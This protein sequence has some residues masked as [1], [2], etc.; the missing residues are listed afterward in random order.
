VKVLN[1][2]SQTLTDPN[3]ASVVLLVSVGDKDIMLMG[4]AENEAQGN[5]AQDTL[6]K[7]EVY[8]VPHHGSAGS[9]YPP[10]L[11]AIH[12]DY[13][14]IEVGAGNSYGHPTPEVLHALEGIGS[15]V[16]RT[17]QNGDVDA[18]VT[19]DGVSVKSER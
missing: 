4:D 7:V 9:Y 13:S 10:F 11:N 16:Y 12:P 8:K 15:K 19:P 6:P 5:M 1:P 14:I 2:S 3:N 18:T 17:D